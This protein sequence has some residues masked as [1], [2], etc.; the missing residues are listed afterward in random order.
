MTRGGKDSSYQ[1]LING[2]HCAYRHGKIYAKFRLR[3]LRT[4]SNVAVPYRTSFTI[5]VQY[6]AHAGGMETTFY[7]SV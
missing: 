2:M 6:G 5:H 3:A 7:S 4:L 1:G